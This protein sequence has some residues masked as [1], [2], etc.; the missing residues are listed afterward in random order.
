M[1]NRA[2][3]P[4]SSRSTRRCDGSANSA[5]EHRRRAS[6]EQQAVADEGDGQ[7]AAHDEGQA[8]VPAAGEIEEVEHLGRVGHAGNRD[9][10]AENAADEEGRNELVHGSARDHVADDVDGDERRRHEGR[11]RDERARRQP[12]DAADAVA[13]RAAIAEMDADADEHAAD[14]E[15]AGRDRNAECDLAAAEQEQQRRDDRARQESRAPLPV[16]R[17]RRDDARTGCRSCRRCGRADAISRTAERPISAPPISDCN[18]VKSVIERLALRPEL[19]QQS[20]Q[21]SRDCPRTPATCRQA[22][23]TKAIA[24]RRGAGMILRGDVPAAGRA[25]P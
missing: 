1:P 2:A 18:G 19:V 5:L 17:E 16:R 8:R 24:A 14:D 3:P 9:A 10:E 12:R 4:I 13:A 25:Q 6:R 23:W 7:A 21:S 15:R 20:I 11:H 22:R